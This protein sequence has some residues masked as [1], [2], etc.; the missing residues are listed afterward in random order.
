MPGAAAPAVV[1]TAR[2]DSIAVKADAIGAEA[3]PG[4]IADATGAEL[5][6]IRLGTK[7]ICP[8]PSYKQAGHQNVPVQDE[9]Q[10]GI[11]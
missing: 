8:R 1:G 11:R 2:A 5:A 10:N 9:F 6:S 7:S 3:F 4:A